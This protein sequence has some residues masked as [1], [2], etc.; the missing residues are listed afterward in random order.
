MHSKWGNA[1]ETVTKLLSKQS[2][3]LKLKIPRS[4]PHQNQRCLKFSLWSRKGLNLKRSLS[5]KR[6]IRNKRP[7]L[8]K[9]KWFRNLRA[10]YQRM[11]SSFQKLSHKL[12]QRIRREGWRSNK[13]NQPRRK[14][15]LANR[16]NQRFCTRLKSHKPS[17]SKLIKAI[18]KSKI[19]SMLRNK[20][21]LPCP[22][23][24]HQLRFM[25]LTMVMKSLE[26]TPNAN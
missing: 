1:L 12:F 25:K 16:K 3:K 21:H 22:F 18:M 14:R 7:I 17:W 11:M 26:R 4:R 24:N 2:P 10:N 20:N 19:N 6:P 8:W 13:R 9:S 23:H 15:V 5:K